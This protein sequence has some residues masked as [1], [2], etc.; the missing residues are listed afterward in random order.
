MHGVALAIRVP[1]SLMS[2][3]A[4]QDPKGRPSSPR[5]KYDNLIGPMTTLVL[6]GSGTLLRWTLAGETRFPKLGVPNNCFRLAKT[7]ETAKRRLRSRRR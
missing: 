4:W 6:K 5:H 3:L 2:A 1:H 7:T